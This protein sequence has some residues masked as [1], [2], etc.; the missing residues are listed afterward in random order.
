M[1]QP[2]PSEVNH[3]DRRLR[4][5]LVARL[6]AMGASMADAEDCAQD[7]LADEFARRAAGDRVGVRLS[8][9]TVVACDRY[10]DLV[11]QRAQETSMGLDVPD[12]ADLAAEQ[13]EE[14]VIRRVQARYLMARL[15]T[16][17]TVTQMVCLL[18]ARGMDR[19]AVAG[20][21]H[22]SVRSVE[23]HLTRARRFLRTHGPLGVV[24]VA[25]AAI[26]ALVRRATGTRMTAATL[27]AVSAGI[28]LLPAADGPPHPAGPDAEPPVAAPAQP[29][30]S[31]RSP[32]G[33]LPG[34]PAAGTPAAANVRA[35]ATPA[36]PPT[37]PPGPSLTV[38]VPGVDLSVPGL[39]VSIPPG[40]PL[41]LPEVGLLSPE[42]AAVPNIPPPRVGLTV[43]APP[44][45]PAQLPPVGL[46]T[47]E[48]PP[49]V[50]IPWP[51]RPGGA[52]R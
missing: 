21:L 20:Q 28:V 40:L 41:P 51:G 22:L 31:P 36:V 48:L 42:L 6:R 12:G 2:D 14:R 52:G 5:I 24:P 35:P 11:Y 4:A 19:R 37:T 9:L 34:D 32:A 43:P 25:V 44:G 1:L 49:G 46:P 23:S 39:D 38:P 16:L 29:G 30:E 47:P 27:A 26:D 3:I 50:P 33:S 45:P 13:P 15:Y 7:A 17:P 8:R 10:A 18:I